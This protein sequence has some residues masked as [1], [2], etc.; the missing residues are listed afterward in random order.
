MNYK[1]TDKMVDVICDDFHLLQVMSRFGISLGVGEKTVREVCEV[2]GV[3]TTTFLAVANYTKNGSGSSTF[4]VERISVRALTQY[5]RQAHTYFLNFQLPAIRRKLV[6]A[7]DCSQNNEVAYLI[8]K[9][10][11]EYMGD[12]RR[13]MNFEDRKVFVYVDKLLEG[14]RT[15]NFQIEK[16]AKSHVGIDGKL[17]ELKNLIL[18][19]YAAPEASEALSIVLFDIFNCEEDL[20]QHC[21]VEDD[22]FVPA[23][24]LLEVKVAEGLGEPAI[25]SAPVGTQDA[26]SD[27][28]REVVSCIVR[29]MTAREVADKLFISSNTVMTHRKNIFRKLDI[30]SVSGLTIYAIVNGIV[31]IDEVKL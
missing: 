19:Y 21:Q 23:V 7:I 3:D 29:G 1:A 8:L 18:K 27:R 14:E 26:L 20:R 22:L 6:E 11:D 2:N 17:Q 24:Q 9:F 13:H 30:H 31:R 5:L 15:E 16:F 12:V 25:A 28:E 10:Y 4:Y